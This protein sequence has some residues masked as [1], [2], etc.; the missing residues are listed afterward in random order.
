MSVNKQRESHAFITLELLTPDEESSEREDWWA[1]DALPAHLRLNNLGLSRTL[2]R[3]LLSYGE[4]FPAVER[5]ESGGEAQLL[6]TYAALPEALKPLAM[7]YL[8]SLQTLDEA[9][10]APEPL[11]EVAGAALARTLRQLST[12]GVDLEI[13]C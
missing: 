7:A 8:R 11:C 12:S 2:G 1:A 13:L 4:G 6:G 9:V 3:L 5:V 10:R